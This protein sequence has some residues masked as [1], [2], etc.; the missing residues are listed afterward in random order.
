M[1]CLSVFMVF[2]ATERWCVTKRKAQLMKRLIPFSYEIGHLFLHLFPLQLFL[3]QNLESCDAAVALGIL[4]VGLRD[5]TQ[6]NAPNKLLAANMTTLHLHL[7]LCFLCQLSKKL[8]ITH[9]QYFLW[10]ILLAL[11]ST[12]RSHTLHPV[13]HSALAEHTGPAAGNAAGVETSE[14][15]SRGQLAHR[16]PVSSMCCIIPLRC[17]VDLIKANADSQHAA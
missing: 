5:K 7:Q 16:T 15:S 13:R 11:A 4:L 3:Q 14:Q 17:L 10:L 6:R 1:A 12:S 9:L 2:L 8:A